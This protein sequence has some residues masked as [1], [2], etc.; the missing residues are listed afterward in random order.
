MTASG[1]RLTPPGSTT[2]NG[3]GD[4]GS[5]G[6][7]ARLWVAA[8]FVALVAAGVLSGVA[9]DRLVLSRGGPRGGPGERGMAY[10]GGMG[11]GRE[12][13]FGRGWGAGGPPDS[14]R[15]RMRDRFA[16]EFGLDSSQRAQID[17]LMARQ[18]PKFRALRE[19]FAPSMDSLTKETQAEMD[20]ILT[21]EQREKMKA[22]RERMRDRRP[23][24][25]RRP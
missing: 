18:E 7:R 14:V 24:E 22:A 21:P 4:S 25:P 11:P 16:E 3:E 2:V 23:G 13:G 17:A 5:T 10:G 1:E 6:V 12:R 9:L 20:W 15:R 8:S 19:R